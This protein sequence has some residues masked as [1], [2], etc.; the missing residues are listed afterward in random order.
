MTRAGAETGR[1]RVL[2]VDDDSVSGLIMSRMLSQQ[3]DFDVTLCQDPTAALQLVTAQAWDLLITDVEMPGMTGLEL[4]EEVRRVD[5]VLP[6]AVVTAYVTVDNA[7]IALRNRA[8]EFLEKPVQPDRLITVAADLVARARAERVATGEIVLA[9]GAH[10]DDVEIGAGGTLL[11]HRA[12]GHR[13]AILTL[14]RGARGGMAAARAL[15]AAE[16]ARILGAELHLEDL[17]DTRISESDPTIAV[18]SSVIE[19]VRP[20]ILYTHSVSD[21]HQDHRNTHHAAMVAARDVGRVYCFQSPSATVEFG[22]SLFAG[23]DGQLSGKIEAIAAFASQASVRDYLE[24]E[25]IQ[26]TARYWGR[27]ARARYAEPF[28]VIRDRGA[29]P[30]GPTSGA[31]HDR[32]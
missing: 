25:L 3:G 19:Q 5:P 22:P 26:S 13:V 9:I 1:A 14:S 23:I 12:L 7:V 27:F 15:E 31:P 2:L 18:I 21:L 24:P 4:L 16:A 6:V 20:T 10:P 8:D 30:T 29:A 32:A 17:R 11:A 28:E